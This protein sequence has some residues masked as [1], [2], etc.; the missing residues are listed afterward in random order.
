MGLV[1]GV[2]VAAV[3]AWAA[4]PWV[5]MVRRGTVDAQTVA[6]WRREYVIPTQRRAPDDARVRERSV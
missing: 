4:A 1:V 6:G 2:A 3:V 5:S